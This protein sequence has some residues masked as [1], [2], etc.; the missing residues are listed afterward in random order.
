[1]PLLD[2]LGL[3]ERLRALEARLAGAASAEADV[4]TRE[5]ARLAAALDETRLRESELVARLDAMAQRVALQQAA[6]DALAARAAATDHAIA[7]ARITDDERRALQRAIAAFPPFPALPRAGYVAPEPW[8]Y[9]AFEIL[10][11]GT[12]EEIA[13][14]LAVHIDLAV[15]AAGECGGLP[16]IDIGCGRGEWLGLAGERGLSAIG[17]DVN[18]DMVAA[19]RALGLDAHVADG[20][21]HLRAVA[22]GAVSVVTAFHVVEH[23]PVNSIVAL[24]VESERVLAPGGLLILET[25]NPENLDVGANT[26]WLDPSHLRPLPPR[27]LRFCV[28]AAGLVVDRVQPLGADPHVTEQAASE[29]WPAG[30]AHALGG[31]RDYAIVARKARP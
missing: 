9:A 7:T 20:I 27:L 6:L 19:C 12:R 17:I 1:M 13:A 21:G 30:L 18:P 2:W 16:L 23:L 31:P 24:L 15:T 11:R 25:P 22:A 3:A 14:R 5:D 26:F 8:F 29:R 10:F 28:E 4:R